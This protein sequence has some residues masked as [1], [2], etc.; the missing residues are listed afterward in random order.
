MLARLLHDLERHGD[1]G[2]DELAR[3]LDCTPDA[4]RGMVQTLTQRGLVQL[5]EPM[6]TCPAGCRACCPSATCY[7]IEPKVAIKSPPG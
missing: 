2:L 7:R 5:V 1:V 6:V 4:V 3:T